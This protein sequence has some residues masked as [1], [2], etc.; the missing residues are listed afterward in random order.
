MEEVKRIKLVNTRQLE[1][2]PEL[3]HHIQSLLPV[4]EAARTCVLSKS[5]LHSWSTIPT[6]RFRQ[7][8]KNLNIQQHKEYMN[9]IDHT[10]IRYLW[11][12]IPITSFKLRLDIWSDSLASHVKKWIQQL[13]LRSCLTEINLKL[14]MNC[15]SFQLPEEI[16]WGENL[17]K[18]SI[19][20]RTLGKLAWL[21]PV[22]SHRTDPLLSMRELVLDLVMIDSSFPEIIYSKFPCLESLTLKFRCFRMMKSLNVT[23]VSLKKLI[24]KIRDDNPTCI[25]VFAPKLLIFCYTGGVRIPNFVFPAIA[26]LKIEL[27]LKLMKSMDNIS[28]FLQ[29]RETLNLSSNFNI[30]ISTSCDFIKQFYIGIDDLR[31]QVPNP[32][33]NVQQLSFKSCPGEDLWGHSEFFDSFFSICSPSYIKA[34][35]SICPTCKMLR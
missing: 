28:F 8:T 20:L 19:N 22:P 27:N 24:I 30:L 5:W 9:M 35:Q 13:V 23:C 4:K 34:I 15:I 10:L 25:H 2:V 31:R 29:M 7:P 6:L 1:D 3:M 16:F 17:K 18:V 14:V 32:A 11:D 21:H 12:D 26:P 33:R